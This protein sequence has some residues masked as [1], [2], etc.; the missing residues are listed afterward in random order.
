M[1]DSLYKFACEE[2]KKVICINICIYTKTEII[3]KE[4]KN[5]NNIIY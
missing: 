4:K 2:N 5:N 3:K 1:N